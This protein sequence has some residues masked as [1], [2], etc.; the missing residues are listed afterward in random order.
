MGDLD[1]LALKYQET[2]FSDLVSSQDWL[3]LSVEEVTRL[4]SSDGVIAP[5]SLILE[6]ILS[7]W[8]EAGLSEQEPEVLSSL[9]GQVRWPLCAPSLLASLETEARYSLVIQSQA[10]TAF[11]AATAS[12]H[13]LA[14]PLSKTA[15]KRGD[16]QQNIKVVEKSPL[17]TDDI[18]TCRNIISPGFAK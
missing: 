13:S 6:A 8:T 11:R 12:P 9:L 5:E 7:W 1:K 3:E 2:Q 14:N 4:V 16:N 10:Y 15:R 18:S 17:T